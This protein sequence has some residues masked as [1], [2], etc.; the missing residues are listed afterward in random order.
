M[1]SDVDLI[2]SDVGS[3][4]SREKALDTNILRFLTRHSVRNASA[5][6]GEESN[7][8]IVAR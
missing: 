2:N 1:D 5:R 7:V 8:R 6:C 3:T 4:N